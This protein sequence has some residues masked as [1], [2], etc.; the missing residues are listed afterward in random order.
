MKPVIEIGDIDMFILSPNG[1]VQLH[2]LIACKMTSVAEGK[3]MLLKSRRF[4]RDTLY[5]VNYHVKN[6][7]ELS[8]SD[9]AALRSSSPSGFRKLVQ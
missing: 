8:A 6:S 9:I 7:C 1:R 5:D 3:I 4:D 2:V